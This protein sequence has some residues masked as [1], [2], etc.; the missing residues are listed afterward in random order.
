MMKHEEKRRCGGFTLIELMIVMAI[1]AVLAAIA[2]PVFSDIL[3]NSKVKADE[4]TVA[5]V[6]TALE[7]Y[8][9]E[10]G[11]YPAMSGDG[12]ASYDALIQTLK[13]TGYL[14]EL[15][16]RDEDRNNYKPQSKKM[17]FTYNGTI[18]Q[19]VPKE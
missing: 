15:G 1:L 16:L 13:T 17:K 19:C 6:G 5:A 7:V 4:A 2:V 9:T 18:V 10:E 8:A 14:K 11:G 3:E 12:E